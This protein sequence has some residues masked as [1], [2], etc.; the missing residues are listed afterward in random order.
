MLL[1]RF[2]RIG[3]AIKLV[4][5]L[6]DLFLHIAN[7]VLTLV[8]DVLDRLRAIGCVRTGR[9]AQQGDQNTNGEYAGQSART[10]AESIGLVPY[11]YTFSRTL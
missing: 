11:F 2:V 7:S 1:I 6:G 8:V 5:K 9:N 3:G 10:H 4:R